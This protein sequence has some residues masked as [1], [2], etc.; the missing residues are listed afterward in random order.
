M[1]EQERALT[2]ALV[3][4]IVLCALSYALPRGLSANVSISYQ[5]L[6]HT[7]GSTHYSLN[8]TVPQS[9][10]EY[11]N[12][13]SHTLNSEHDFA[14][15]VTPYALQPIAVSLMQIYTDDEDFTNGVLMIVHQILYEATVP[16]KYPVETMVDNKG[17]CDLFSFIAASIIK[18]GG[19]NT[20]LLYYESEAHMNV[21]VSLSQAPQDSREVAS[22]VTQNNTRYYVAECTG[23][24]WQD[25]WRVG[26]CPPDLKGANPEIITLDNSEQV[27]T[28]QVSAS[29]ITLVTS[30]L[31][32]TASS[33]YSL[34]G[35]I[36]TFS[37]QLSPS[38]P[39]ENITIYIR[40]NNSPW[41][42]LDTVKTDSQGRFS[43]A[44]SAD[45]SGICYVRASYSGSDGYSVAD[46]STRSLTVLSTFFVVLIALVVVLV[47]IGIAAFVMGRQ[48]YTGI[49]E[50]QPPEIPS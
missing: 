41:I 16:P 12:A 19:L 23:G 13:K 25:G 44:W 48:T 15:F 27:A 17:D 8:V 40:V 6:N 11:Y 49:P 26:E 35:D 20:V 50:P 28:G 9:L 38:L 33:S 24:K 34:Q 30:S 7:D 39:N 29:Y 5:L 42:V 10:L 47:C 37:G 3:A 31:T 1:R 21:A 14:K 45:V 46:S 43:Y 36:V 32:L 22:F 18:A 4:T 2:K